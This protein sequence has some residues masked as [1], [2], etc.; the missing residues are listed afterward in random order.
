MFIAVLLMLFH[1]LNTYSVLGTVP[2]AEITRGIK[3][4]VRHFRTW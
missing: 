1:F 2:S 3:D 4:A